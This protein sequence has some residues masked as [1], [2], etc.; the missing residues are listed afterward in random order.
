[1]ITW[2]NIPFTLATS[3][4]FTFSGTGIAENDPTKQILV[5]TSGTYAV[6]LISGQDGS[7]LATPIMANIVG[8]AAVP[9]PSTY[10]AIAAGMVLT[11][12]IYRRRRQAE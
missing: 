12:A 8:V 9:E 5:P 3:D 11:F 1:M 2:I 4:T 6:H 10:A 7:S